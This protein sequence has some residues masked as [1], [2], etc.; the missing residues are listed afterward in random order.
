MKK[1]KKEITKRQAKAKDKA[2]KKRQLRLVKK[3]P[4]FIERPPITE[5]EAPKGF[6]AIS[7]S[8][9]IMEYAQPLMETNSADISELN[10]KMDLA[11]SLWNL[12]TSKQKNN[13]DEYAGWMKKVRTDVRSVLS[14]DGEEMDRFIEEMVQRHIYLF[15][16]EIQPAPPSMFMYMRKD[17]SYLIRPFDPSFTVPEV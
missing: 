17:A 9:A 5:M 11:S 8:Q 16:A 2:K 1:N 6:I 13:A 12:A 3:Q 10:R 14:L 4:R 7:M 15:P